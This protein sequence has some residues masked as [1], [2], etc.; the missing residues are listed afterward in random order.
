MI[1]ANEVVARWLVEHGLPGVFRVHLPP[2][3]QKLDDATCTWA[4]GT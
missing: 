1:F 4:S 2:D 3:P